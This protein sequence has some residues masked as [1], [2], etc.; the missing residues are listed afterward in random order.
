MPAMPKAVITDA[1]IAGYAKAA[2]FSGNAL[3]IAV[4]VA[5]G[6]SGGNVNAHNPIGLDDS[7]GLWQINMLG[8]LGPARRKQFGISRNEELYNPAVNAKAAYA[9]SNGGKSWGP[10]SVYTSGK[11]LG[12]MSRAR[13]AAGN[14]DTSGG[15]TGVQPAGITDVFEWPGEIMDFLEFITDPIT[16]LRLGMILAGGGLLA[17]ALFKLSGQA[18]KVAK[19]VDTATDV[20]PQTR[21]IKAAAKAT[22]AA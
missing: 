17:I 18:D 20:L 2:G 22:K 13:K 5:L 4:A 16:W 14:P 15:T 3:V 12:Y 6:E 10:W 1:Q 7:Y 19:I 21:G 9:I 8:T 11:Y